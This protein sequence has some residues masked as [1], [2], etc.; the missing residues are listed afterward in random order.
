VDELDSMYEFKK[1]R[2]DDLLETQK[3]IMKRQVDEMQGK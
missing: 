1:K 2:D 3:K